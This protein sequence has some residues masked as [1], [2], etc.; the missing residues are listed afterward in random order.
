[1]NY[2]PPTQKQIR[3]IR[4]LISDESSR[5]DQ[6]KNQVNHFL[7]DHLNTDTMFLAMPKWKASQLIDGILDQDVGK[8]FELTTIKVRG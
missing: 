3:M 8:V 2:I 4:Y 1:M 5:N 7:A 6:I